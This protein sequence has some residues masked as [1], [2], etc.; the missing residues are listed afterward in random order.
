M[1]KVQKIKGFSNY[2]IDMSDFNDVKVFSLNYHTSCCRR[3]LKPGNCNK[4]WRVTLVNDEGKQVGIGLHQLVWR[5][6]NGDIPKGHDIHHINF[7]PNDNRPEN[8]TLMTHSEHMKLHSKI[9]NDNCKF[10]GIKKEC[11]QF[12]SSWNLVKTWE[13]G[14]EASNVYGPC[15]RSNLYHL[16]R[17]KTAYGFIWIY[18]EEYEKL[19]RENK[20]EAYK[21]SYF[22]D[23][24]TPIVVLDKS[25]NFIAEYESMQA[26]SR[27]TGVDS[28]S[29]CYC[30]KH[31]YGYKSAKGYKFLYKSEYESLS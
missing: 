26:A 12:D 17:I 7:D 19:V 13:S 8:L 4:H 23:I 20:W 18:K 30:C 11:M 22:K 2:E 5:Q 15:V 3:Q 6:F 25:G 21:A 10:G 27:A 9:A 24:L 14:K 28:G 1:N 16:N 29:I 31:T